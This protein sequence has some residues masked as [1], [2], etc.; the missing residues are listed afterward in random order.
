[1]DAR[2]GDYLDDK[3]Q[4]A[5]DL[6][7]LDSLLDNVKEQQ[8]LLKKQLNDARRD[9]DEAQTKSQQHVSELQAKADAFRKEQSDIDRRLL[10]VTQ[11]ETSDEAV[12]KFEA[13]MA[14][15][16]KLDVAAGY[17]ELLKE[18]EALCSE[19]TSQL[20]KS[21]EAALEPY[22]RL[23]HLVNALRPLQ[24]A[25]EGAAPHLLDHIAQRVYALRQTIQRS[26]SEDLEKTLKKM[27]WPK[28]TATVPLAFQKEWEKNVGRLLDLQKPELE[29]L[30]HATS[31]GQL[32]TDKPVLLPLEV[33]AKPLEQRFAY[34]FSGNK[35]TARLDKPE[36]FLTHTTDVIANYSEFVQN[37]LQGLLVQRFRGTDLAFV[38]A[39]IDAT[40]AFVTA[41]LPMIRRKLASTASQVTSQPN[42]LSHLVHEVIAFDT[43]LHETYAYSPA[44]PSLPWQ[45]LA[46]YLLD[47]LGHFP[48]WLSV[49]RD[50]ALSRYNAI[51][52]STD[53]HD[54]DYDSVSSTATKPS[55]ATIRVNDLMETIT[56]RYKPLS[57]FSQKLRFLIDIQISIFD[58]FHSRLHSSLEAYMAKTAP[59]AR[60]LSTVTKEEQEALRGV[61]G[62]DYLCRVF[63]S[64]DY[65]E[66]AMRDWSD[67]IFFIEL[68][69]ELQ[70]RARNRDT[71]SSKLESGLQELQAK[72]SA[73][74]VPSDE[75]NDITQGALFDETASA[76]QRLRVRSE[77]ILTE[78]LTQQLQESLRP[79]LRTN[80][81]A[82]LSS[83][84]SSTSTSSG[85]DPCLTTLTSSFSFLSKAL[86]RAPLLRL[87]RA[88]TSALSSTLLDNL[89]LRS[90]FSTAGAAQLSTDVDALSQVL[91]RF[92]GS[93]AVETGL[94][95]LVEAVTLLALPVRSE[96]QREVPGVQGQGHEDDGASA[97]EEDA[98]SVQEDG[99]D[100]GK[101]RPLGLFEVERMVFRS[102][103]S[104]REALD[105]LGLENMAEGVARQV[106]ERRVEVQG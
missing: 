5:A 16:R 58:Q 27:E 13:S 88:T 102:N 39:Y 46:H 64:A 33:M 2:L 76:Y 91:V 67:D 48:L 55:K 25:A 77:S 10:I 26:F 45:G 12:E 81:W 60:T 72:T 8:E 14:R 86:G 98:T 31:H 19:C 62:L 93:R 85:L 80:T 36:Y 30:E 43:V 90:N 4:S 22:R 71:I 40:S 89:V 68:W 82:T 59:I 105:A 101:D 15:L 103:E 41:L 104:A 35:Q 95:G 28:V 7:T 69:E 96:I 99:A 79:Y 63:G 74:L 49:E 66:R 24:E 50:F 47:T 53:S 65:L 34:H 23:Q 20:G 84:S 52:S 54:L 92:A 21:D 11:S 42:L 78:T 38:P 73:A 61:K 9:H 70:F 100:V 18:V 6:Q 57:S 3:L 32:H 1:M 97:W 94:R 106:L 37:S 83:S 17:V 75:I 44:S 56:D 51:I 87:S 29:G